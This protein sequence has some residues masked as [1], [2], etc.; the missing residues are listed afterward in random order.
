MNGLVNS[1][2][3][4]CSKTKIGYGS[5]TFNQCGREWPFGGMNEAGLVIEMMM[6]PEASY[7]QP[8]SRKAVAMTPWIQYQLDNF[9]AVEE[10]LNVPKQISAL[11]AL[12][13]AIPF[14][15]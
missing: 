13:T 7:P 15:R 10:T 8:D 2:S 5:V 6:H 14:T 4:V 1:E 3:R 12:N 11:A 9:N